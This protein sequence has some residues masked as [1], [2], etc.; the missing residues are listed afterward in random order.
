MSG[1]GVPNATVQNDYVVARINMELPKHE[2]CE[3][4]GFELN[5]IRPEK[6]NQ[7]AFVLEALRQVWEI[8]R[9]WIIVCNEERQFRKKISCY[10]LTAGR[11]R[12]KL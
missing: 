10:V 1:K 8:T 6:P 11:E 5:Y 7:N 4:R 9:V 2:W 12:Q 3:K